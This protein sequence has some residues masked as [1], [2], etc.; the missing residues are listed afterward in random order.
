MTKKVAVVF[1]G[2]TRSLP[3]TIDAMNKN[4]FQPILDA[5]MEYDIFIHN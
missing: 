5:G 1:F 4:V 3:D 2:L